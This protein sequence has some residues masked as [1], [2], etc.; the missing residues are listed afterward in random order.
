MTMSTATRTRDDSGDRTVREL[1]DHSRAIEDDNPGQARAMAQQAR[2]LARA[3][4][5]QPGESEALY[6]LARV[7]YSLASTMHC[8]WPSRQLSWRTRVATG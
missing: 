2:V 1:L 5:D 6:L 4:H 7:S 8:R 3:H